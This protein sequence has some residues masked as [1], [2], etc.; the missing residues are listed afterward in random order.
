VSVV[1]VEEIWDGRGGDD[2]VKMRNWVR[3]WRVITDDPLDDAPTAMG[4]VPVSPGDPHPEDPLSF[5]KKAN[6]RQSATRLVWLVTISYTSEREYQPNPLND[7][8]VINW[9][10]EPFQR[11]LVKDK[12][13]RAVLNSAGD[14]FDPPIMR[15]D[16]RPVVNVVKN[17]GSVPLFVLNYRDVVNSDQFQ[18]DGVTIGVGKGKIKWIPVSPWQQRNGFYYRI[19]TIQITLNKEGWNFKPLQQGYRQRVELEEAGGLVQV[20]CWTKDGKQ[21]TSPALL[22]E[23]GAQIADPDPDSAVFGDFEGYEEVPFSILPLA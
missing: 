4:A 10:G 14:P 3:V 2:D 5:A 21:V 17:V 19:L 15:D 11:P 9:D 12:D 6:A 22:D 20:P 23:T 16:N 8:A 13:G 7:P 1:S 18:V